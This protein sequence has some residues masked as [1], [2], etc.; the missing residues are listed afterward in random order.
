MFH[1]KG[2]ES[3]I[4][5]EGSSWGGLVG[6]QRVSNLAHPKRMDSMVL[7]LQFKFQH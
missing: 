2:S 7:S 6:L 3:Y 5:E 1:L 4:R